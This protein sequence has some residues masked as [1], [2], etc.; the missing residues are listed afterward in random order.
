MLTMKELKN[1]V[2]E[3]SERN[4]GAQVSKCKWS[5]LEGQALGS[6]APLLGIIEEL[7]EMEEAVALLKLEDV[8]DS[9]GDQC[10]YLAD[11]CRREGCEIPPPQHTNMPLL[12]CVRGLIH[13]TLKSHQG[14]RG[15]DS[16]EK[17]ME[18]RDTALSL[19]IGRL[20][21]LSLQ[22]TGETLN[23]VANKVWEKVAKRDWQKNKTNAHEE[24]ERKAL[25]E[26]QPHAEPF[27]LPPVDPLDELDEG[28]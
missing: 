14:I 27:P 6:L 25:E 21:Q 9:I 12:A 13:A 24:A 16:A 18:V 19:Y 7:A 20:S 5:K 8:K 1:A 28:N 26:K 22:Y 17:Y 23:A 11:Y 2:G 10:I 4:F 3:W 15:F